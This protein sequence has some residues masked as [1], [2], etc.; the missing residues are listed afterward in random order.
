MKMFAT[1][2]LFALSLSAFALEHSAK[3][4]LT[5]L[6]NNIN[7]GA[8][9]VTVKLVSKPT[10]SQSGITTQIS[11]DDNDYS[12]TTTAAF[13]VGEM[14]FSVTQI[15]TNWK[16]VTT[17]KV[18]GQVT[19]TVD[20]QTCDLSLENLA[21]QKSLHISVSPVEGILVLPVKA[22]AGY[23]RV[24][25]YLAPFAGYLYSMANVEIEGNKLVVDPS[26]ILSER[27]LYPMMNS[28]NAFKLYYYVSAIEGSSG[29]SLGNGSVPLQ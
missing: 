5:S 8:Y 18:Y 27:N 29:L 1:L 17:Q 28:Y 10:L 22:P 26:E 20:G 6:Y 13:E 23:S 3:L 19:H 25:T 2:G 11:R 16:K 12:C 24:Q 21:G 7:A 4:D 9:K 14:T 15:G